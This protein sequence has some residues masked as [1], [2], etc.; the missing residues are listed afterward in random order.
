MKSQ[1]YTFLILVAFISVSVFG[2]YLF[3]AHVGHEVDC[4]FSIGE[5]ALCA[6]PFEQLQHWQSA[7]TAVLAEILVFGVLILAFFTRPD[8]FREGGHQYV[9]YRSWD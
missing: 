4:P 8:V 3:T 7:F 1:F 5:T 2:L 6:A 9:R